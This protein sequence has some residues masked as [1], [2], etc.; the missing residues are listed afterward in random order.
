MLSTF[1]LRCGRVILTAIL[2]VRAPNNSHAHNL[3]RMSEGG[4]NSKSSTVAAS[5]LDI[6]GEGVHGGFEVVGGPIHP[7]STK[8]ERRRSAM[9]REEEMELEDVVEANEF[10]HGE[11]LV[12]VSFTIDLQ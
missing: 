8:Y 12:S 10:V 6:E 2:L 11:S 9:L 1:H 7:I 3:R 5:N 4:T